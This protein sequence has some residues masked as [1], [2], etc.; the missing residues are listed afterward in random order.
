M[1][2]AFSPLDSVVPLF[3]GRCPRLVWNRAFGPELRTAPSEATYRELAASL[4]SSLL[5]SD[6]ATSADTRPLIDRHYP[7]C[8]KHIMTAY[9][10]HQPKFAFV[11]GIYPE[12]V[13]DF[14]R[15]KYAAD[16][17]M[18]AVQLATG[19]ND[20]DMRD[21]MKRYLEYFDE[22]LDKIVQ[23]RH[24]VPE[25]EC[26]QMRGYIR[27]LL[28]QA[29][30]AR[31][32]LEEGVS[33]NE[34]FDLIAEVSKRNPRDV[35][36]KLNGLVVRWRIA[37]A[38]RKSGEKYNPMAGLIN[39]AFVD[40]RTRYPQEFEQF[41]NRLEWSTE[42]EGSPTYGKALA[43]ALEAAKGEADHEKRIA[44][45]RTVWP[46]EKSAT[47]SSLIET[48][49]KDSPWC[50]VLSSGPGRW[51]LSE[52]AHR[53]ETQEAYEETEAREEVR[54]PREPKAKITAE[55]AAAPEPEMKSKE[56]DSA[57]S[58][59]L[60]KMVSIEAGEFLMGSPEGEEGGYS[61]ERPQHKVV[62]EG[63]EI[64]ATPVTQ[65]QYEAVMGNNPAN[66][67]GE[68]RPVEKVS[69]EDA[70]VFCEQLTKL[71]KGSGR[72][73]TLPSEAQ[74]EYA[75]RAGRQT[76]YY[77]GDDAGKLGDYAWYAEN[78]G[79]ETHPVCEKEL[80]DWGLYDMHGNVWEWC[81]DSWQ[82]SYEGA[83]DDGSA[84]VDADGTFRV[85]RGGS[86]YDGARYCRSAF[87]RYD[88]P[89]NRSLNV[90]FRV[91]T[92]PSSPESVS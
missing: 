51:W 19:G 21:R 3:L 63:F 29:D 4:P 23:V 11:L 64:G 88:T 62:L 78:S 77:F 80:N 73:F 39:E 15:N 24:Y 53:K 13:E 52:A 38:E 27:K 81:E 17:P 56:R 33:E 26:K 71:A 37:Q 45:L 54:E 83:P 1:E 41:V 58:Q 57:L 91:L 12:I 8:R 2:R 84:W 35:V 42:D 70:M 89:D 65:A 25:R 16:Y 6:G 75:C 74:W 32:F 28:D 34:L 67:K 10:L 69:W 40:R 68:K 14:I 76:A 46:T 44:A 82:G 49:R 85:I 18:A 92:V 59:I 5:R 47:M 79:S 36:R 90:G 55:P 50:N 61:D 43:S 7:K 60:D 72:R 48:L 9:I 30:M 66:F 87:R 20:A 86:W 31:A 22:Y